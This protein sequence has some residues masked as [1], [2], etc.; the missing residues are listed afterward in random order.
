MIEPLNNM[1]GDMAA[2]ALLGWIRDH[3]L[4]IPGLV[5]GNS[6][7]IV[8]RIAPTTVY[9]LI[10]L[11]DGWYVGALS[12]VPPEGSTPIVSLDTA[13]ED[14]LRHFYSYL[15]SEAAAHRR[16]D[17]RKLAFTIGDFAAESAL[18]LRF[19]DVARSIEAQGLTSYR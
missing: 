15:G 8:I 14:V 17:R 4:V 18:A 5:Q 3:N 13:P 1:D 11:A 7:V 6:D 16:A 9:S 12:G 10:P 19:E 2:E